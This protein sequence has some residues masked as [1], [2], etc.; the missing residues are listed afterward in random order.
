[1]T[2]TTDDP[3]IISVRATHPS[4]HFHQSRPRTG[5]PLEVR[6]VGRSPL[7]V[8]LRGA[9]P[10]AVVGVDVFDKGRSIRRVSCTVV[11]GGEIRIGN[12]RPGNYDLATYIRDCEGARHEIPIVLREGEE[13]RVVGV[14]N[15]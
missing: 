4:F 3:K 13:T 2:I 8:D 7:I 14:F 9:H 10:G 11:D 1:M 6:M 15:E 12:V 5:F